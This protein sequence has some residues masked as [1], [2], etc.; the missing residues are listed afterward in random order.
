MNRANKSIAHSALLSSN[1][2]KNRFAEF[3]AFGY[4]PPK[5]FLGLNGYPT[6]RGQS[7]NIDYKKPFRDRIDPKTN[8]TILSAIYNRISIDIALLTFVHAQLDEDERFSEAK[9]SDLNYC[10]NVSSNLD[11]TPFEFRYNMM[12][13]LLDKGDLAVVPVD[14]D[15]DPR[16][17]DSYDI[18][19]LRYGEIVQWEPSRVKVRLYNE[20]TGKYEEIF[21]DKKWT[22]IL[23][24]PFYWIMNEPNSV[25]ARLKQKLSMLDR[26]DKE[27]SSGR[28]D[29]II[30]LPYVLKT[31]LQKKQAE[32]RKKA[33]EMQLTDSKYGI[34]YTDGTERITQLNRAVE[35][36]L[37]VQI[38]ELKK[39]LIERIGITEAIINGSASEEEL[40]NYY[41]RII[42]PPVTAI[43]Q[44]F[45][46]KFLSKTAISQHQSIEFF[47]DP[48][49]LIPVS[50]IA[51][52]ADK[53]T[54]N[55]IATSN[56]IRTK[57]GWEPSKDPAADELRNK[58]INQ[59]SKEPQTTIER[60]EENQNED[61]FQ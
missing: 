4:S 8:E 22:A 47:R 51:D 41:S 11:Q 52:I 1:R 49:K 23:E 32:E 35:S 48:F 37:P 57:I 20:E 44:E 39:E 2:K 27:Q 33:I 21:C 45:R 9:K 25:G 30:Q 34:A 59:S 50:K 56:E 54:R 58:N 40:T 55:E 46:R 12:M 61:G 16:F 18:S 43:C 29:L 17:T 42:E 53:L 24:N 14:T 10:L 19:S 31:K 6:I 36:N 7:Y 5:A 15:E 13:Q 28:L 60:S 38:A 3:Q 26:L